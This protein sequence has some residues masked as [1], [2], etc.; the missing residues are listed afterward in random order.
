[1]RQQ[2]LFCVLALVLIAASLLLVATDGLIAPAT[3]HGPGNCPI[4]TWASCLAVAQVPAIVAWIEQTVFH[5]APHEPGL[6]FY[7]QFFC[8]SFSARSPP[9]SATA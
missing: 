4:C 7:A 5:Q 1:M 3:K 8:G 2:R 9:P 6:V